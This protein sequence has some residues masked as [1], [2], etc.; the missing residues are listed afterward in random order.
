V[1]FAYKFVSGRFFPADYSGSGTGKVVVQI[2]PGDT[3]TVIGDRLYTL[4][5]VGSARAFVNAAEA[6]PKAS[7]LQPGFYSMHKHMNATL[8]F[9]LLLKPSSR[10]QLRVTTPEGLRVSQIIGTLAH[11][12]SIPLADFQQALR[13]PAALGL[14][15]YAHGN[16]EGYLFPATYTIQPGMTATSV[17]QAMVKAYDQEAASVNLTHAAASGHLTAAEVIVVASLAQAEGGKLSDFPKITRVIYNR[18]AAGMPLQLDS[19]VM[20]ALHTYGIAASNSQ[21]NVSSPYNTYRNKGLPPGPIDAPGDAAIRAALHPASG[22]WLYFVTVNPKT[23]QTDFTSSYAVF[24][25]LQAQL[26]RNQGG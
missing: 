10:I 25:Q 17:L 15:S 14:P 6:S 8:A 21:L 1:Y 26:N 22:N 18:L 16:P 3:A 23:K 2:Q 20:Y 9:S 4:G 13:H 24:Q 5:V 12:S 7:S 19:T 11:G